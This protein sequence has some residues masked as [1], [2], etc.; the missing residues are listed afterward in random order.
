MAAPRYRLV[1]FDVDD[2]LTDSANGGV[3]SPVVRWLPGR[4]ARLRRLR[5]EGVQLA[6]A[7]NQG[8]VGLGYNSEADV[9]AAIDR[10]A[11]IVAPPM[12]VFAA[13]G[14]PRATCGGRRSPPRSRSAASGCGRRCSGPR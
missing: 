14:H 4:V 10:V 2:T 11:R 1:I 9:R 3:D 6:L 7:T 12:T 13:F 5:A 8:G